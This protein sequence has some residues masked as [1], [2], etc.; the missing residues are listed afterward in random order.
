[1]NKIPKLTGLAATVFLLASCQNAETDNTGQNTDTNDE[2]STTETAADD[3]TVSESEETTED[4]STD[5]KTEEDTKEEPDDNSSQA[6]EETQVTTSYLIDSYVYSAETE[7]LTAFTINR[8]ETQDLSPGESL[9]M[10][11]VDNDPSEQE[12]LSSFT[13]LTVDGSQLHVNF[14]EEGTQLST[15]TALSTM[16]YDSL[17]GISDLYG[18]EQISFFNPEGEEEMIVAERMVDQPIVIEEERAPS[19]GYYTIYDKESEQTFF[20]PAGELGE[21]ATTEDDETLSFPDALEAMS[22]VENEETFYSS[23]LVDGLEIKDASFENGIATVHYTMDE[24]IATENDRTVL[25]NAIQLTALD[26]DAA[27]ARLVNESLQETTIY[28]L[29]EQ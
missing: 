12:I 5:E 16:F 19:H 17:L 29:L 27:E 6:Y 3:N 10:S 25:E 4:N 14:S 13:E 28:P 26:Y 8:D 21:P 20:L 23:A 15:T 18:I 7:F 9:E 1:M 11:L 2:T 24:E 22:R